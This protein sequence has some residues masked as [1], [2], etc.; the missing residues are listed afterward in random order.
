MQTLCNLE[1]HLTCARSPARGLNSLPTHHYCK[2][3]K[4]HVSFSDLVSKFLCFHIAKKEINWYRIVIEL[5]AGC[6]IHV[7]WFAYLLLT[8]INRGVTLISSEFK[9]PDEFR[10]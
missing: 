9:A 8:R 6:R 10:K 2:H 7:V 4:A 1:L 5:R 3:F